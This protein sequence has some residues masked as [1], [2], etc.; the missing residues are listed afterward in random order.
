MRY[1]YKNYEI[2]IFDEPNYTLN[3]VDNFREYGNIY[4]EGKHHEDKF[5]PTNK[6]SI[7]IKEFDA[8]ITSAIICEIGGATA[9][10]EKSFIIEN[11]KI[12]ICICNK[13][14]CLIIPS[15]QLVWYK[16]IDYVTNFSINK[17]QNDFIVHGELEIIRISKEG[18]IKWRFG[19]RDIFVSLTEKNNFKIENDLIKVVD[20]EGYK[21]ILD[22]NGKEIY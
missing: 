16:Q 2:E 5:Y 3:S 8:E 6:Q 21:Y 14:Y 7:I 15:L 17:F 18:E 11:D 1:N 10:N 13:I 20:F 22:E 12:W 4:F 19:A 9:V